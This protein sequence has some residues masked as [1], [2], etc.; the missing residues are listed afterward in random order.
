MKSKLAAITSGNTLY[1]TGIHTYVQ[2]CAIKELLPSRASLRL[3]EADLMSESVR[4]I[5]RSYVM[6]ATHVLI[7]PC[8]IYGA[9]IACSAT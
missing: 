9:L 6:Y 5:N 1:T 3:G 4:R 8:L 7:L 2:L